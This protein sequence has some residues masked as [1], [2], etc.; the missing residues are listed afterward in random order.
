MSKRKIICQVL[1]ISIFVRYILISQLEGKVMSMAD[2]LVEKGNLVI[3][4]NKKGDYQKAIQLGEEVLEECRRV[5][6]EEHPDTLAA[7]SNLAMSYD[8]VGDYQIGLVF[9]EEILKTY[10][11]IYGEDHSNTLAAKSNL[12]M[13]YDNVGKYQIALVLR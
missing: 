7:K 1:D 8:N 11:K 3:F 2:T 10:R 12:A 6:G 5:L 13:S 9:R 4:Y